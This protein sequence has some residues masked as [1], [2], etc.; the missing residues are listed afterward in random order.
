MYTL[1]LDHRKIKKLELYIDVTHPPKFVEADHNNCYMYKLY[2]SMIEFIDG[3]VLKFP[4]IDIFSL[5]EKG[6]E[7]V[8]I[9]ILKHHYDN[10]KHIPNYLYNYSSVTIHNINNQL[11]SDTYSDIYKIVLNIKDKTEFAKYKL[12]YMK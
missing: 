12:K 1:I 10:N 2:V 5:H 8:Y 9:K 3:N 6:Y 11:L 4:D 7:P